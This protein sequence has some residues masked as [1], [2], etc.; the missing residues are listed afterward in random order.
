MAAKQ[1]HQAVALSSHDPPCRNVT[2]ASPIKEPLVHI[3]AGSPLELGNSL[4]ERRWIGNADISY[5]APEDSAPKQAVIRLVE[6]LSGKRRIIKAYRHVCRSH[7]PGAD[8]FASAVNSLDL[9]VAYDASKLVA[10]PREG[11]LVVVANHPFGVIDG[12]VLCH[13]IALARRDFKVVAMSTLCC[14]PEIREHVLPINFAAT[15]E[16]AQISAR[17]RRL[18]KMHLNAGGCVI[19][20]PAGAVST[21]RHVFGPAEDAEWHPFVARL[22][23]AAGA[24]V[25]PVHFTGQNSL[26]FQLVSQ[27]SSTLRLSLLMQEAAK[28]IGTKVDARIGDVL[29]F[30]HLRAFTEPKA[31]IDHLR[32]A[33]ICR[34]MALAVDHLTAAGVQ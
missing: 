23:V 2:L 33:D 7:R 3:E 11:P 1:C 27:F 6:Q 32:A 10:V 25:L 14:V 34:V 21:S 19:I 24:P 30:D 8:I 20:F 17:S 28:R 9:T 31:L 15:R 29:P 5:A 26:L 13:L 12:L 4:F 16:A 22:I 18:A